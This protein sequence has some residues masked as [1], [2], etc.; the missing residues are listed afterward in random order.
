[1]LLNAILRKNTSII[2][3]DISPELSQVHSANATLSEYFGN[4]GQIG[5]CRMH[6]SFNALGAS[7]PTGG[8]ASRGPGIDQ[9]PVNTFFASDRFLEATGII[10][11]YTD[12]VKYPYGEFDVVYNL[13][14]GISSTWRL[15]DY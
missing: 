14:G 10:R 1:V 11:L 9:C 6:R 2:C 8:G 13:Q 7:T 4:K 5:L 15:T 3:R 12:A